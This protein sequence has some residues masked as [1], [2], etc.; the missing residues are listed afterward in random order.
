MQ[1]LLDKLKM[2][3]NDEKPDPLFVEEVEDITQEKT[4]TLRKKAGDILTDHEIVQIDELMRF[5]ETLAF[6]D[7]NTLD[8]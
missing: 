2:I 5:V 1:D 7:E 3:L 6:V 4:L 8:A